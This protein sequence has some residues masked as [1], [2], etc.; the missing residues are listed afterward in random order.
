MFTNTYY[1]TRNFYMLNIKRTDI[2]CQACDEELFLSDFVQPQA[3]WILPY[4][5]TTYYASDATVICL[6][7]RHLQS[8]GHRPSIKHF[9]WLMD[10]GFNI[11]FNSAMRCN[12]CL[13]KIFQENMPRAQHYI[14]VLGWKQCVWGLAVSRFISNGLQGQ[15]ETEAETQNQVVSTI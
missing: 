7:S 1:L 10:L 3:M 14:H 2:Q 9:Q 5:T 11:F 12:S 8:P 15:W 4:D 13:S 6:H